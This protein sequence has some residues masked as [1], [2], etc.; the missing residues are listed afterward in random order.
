MTVA[1]DDEIDLRKIILS[2]QC[3]R[4]KQLSDGSFRFINGNN[5]LYIRDRGGG[6]FDVSCDAAEWDT[7]WR[8]YFDLSRNYREI[9]TEISGKDGYIDGAVKFGRGIR[10]LRQD[11]WETLVTFIISQRKNIPA[12]AKS[13]EMI[14]EKY[15]RK[16]TTER[17]TLYIFP[18]AEKMR[19]ASA[20]ELNKCGLGY[21]TR[22][23]SDAAARVSTRETDLD[24]LNSLSDGELI[25]ALKRIRGVGAKVANCVALFAY[26]RTACVP[27]DVWIGRAVGEHFGGKSPFAM[28]GQYAGIVQQY[29]FFRERQTARPRP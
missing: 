8:E 25:E 16:I 2:G 11:P 12:I 19:H 15:G 24:A 21:R 4:A 10:I 1:I 3:F 27:V 22:Y 6:Y 28:F 17:E 20:E 14:A 7:V 23:V 18:T 26:G 13:V 5:V 29:V 9:N